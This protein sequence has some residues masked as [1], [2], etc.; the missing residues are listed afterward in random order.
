MEFPR[1]GS[2]GYVRYA[3]AGGLALLAVCAVAGCDSR[4]GIEGT[5]YSTDEPQA[6]S[7]PA[8]SST[9]APSTPALRLDPGELGATIS[10]TKPDSAA[11]D[12]LTRWAMDLERL[13]PDR[14]ADKCWTLAPQNATSM[15]TDKQAILHALAQP[16][17]DDGTAITWRGTG[18]SPITVIAQRTDIDTGYACPRV[19]P[20]HTTP[21]FNDADARH[22]VRRYLARTTGEPLDP[23]DRESTHPLVCAAS[24]A[25]WDPNGSDRPTSA[26]LATD[27]GKLTGVQSFV[28]QAITSKAP[29]GG[30]ISVSVPILTATGAQQDRIFTLKSGPQGYCIGDVSS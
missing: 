1:P 23:A 7:S 17:V 18:R 4:V 24:P 8:P 27:P 11:A 2:R 22:T 29:R 13:P 9:A 14:L 10:L 25:T 3:L 16:G 21:G 30:Y 5:D 6:P 12:A 20:A 28:D 19:F 26:P 15:Y